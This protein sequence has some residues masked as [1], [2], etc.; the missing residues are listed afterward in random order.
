MLLLVGSQCAPWLYVVTTCSDNFESE[1]AR[2]NDQLRSLSHLNGADER[3]REVDRRLAD[4][5]LQYELLWSQHQDAT[6]QIAELKQDL[7]VRQK[8]MAL[9][10]SVA[11]NSTAANVQQLQQLQQA[12]DALHHSHSQLQQQYQSLH[13]QCEELSSQ[14]HTSSAALS[15]ERSM[16]NNSSKDKLSLQHELT[17][18]QQDHARLQR[19]YAQL[20]QSEGH[21]QQS[22]INLQDELVKISESNA[23]FANDSLKLNKELLELRTL[24]QTLQNSN[25]SLQSAHESSTADLTARAQAQL[26]EQIRSY[27]QQISRLQQQLLASEARNGELNAM[28][29]ATPRLGA[30]DVARL[31]KQERELHAAIAKLLI[32][33]EA[34]EASFTCYW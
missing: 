18:L 33:E 10:R 30:A 29:D 25:K 22:I 3:V 17:T 4:N 1:I 16:A 26:S 5:K 31:K 2:L 14:L 19:D 27:E 13:E 23:K 11:N 32:N 12:Y 28:M 24:V 9:T 15:Q 7:A 8:E 20:Q 6:Y 21:A 34:S